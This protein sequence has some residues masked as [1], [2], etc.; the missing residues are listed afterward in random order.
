MEP[1]LIQCVRC[2]GKGCD[3]CNS[4]GEIE[5]KSCARKEIDN[6]VWRMLKWYLR[7]EQGILPEDGNGLSQTQS[8]M[9]AVDFF[10]LEFA[11]WKRKLRIDG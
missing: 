6:D 10:S 11:E 2:S 7:G 9:D 8:Y 5:I 4:T 3:G 1:A